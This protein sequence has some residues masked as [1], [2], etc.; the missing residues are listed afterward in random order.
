MVRDLHLRWVDLVT[1]AGR[2]AYAVRLEG[3]YRLAK[4]EGEVVGS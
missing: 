2:R 1:E 4:P 3:V